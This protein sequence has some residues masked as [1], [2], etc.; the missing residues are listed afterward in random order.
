LSNCD[1]DQKVA[2]A[3]TS[4]VKVNVSVKRS[5]YCWVT[6]QL[7]DCA[8]ISGECR[9]IEKGGE[10]I[11]VCHKYDFFQGSSSVEST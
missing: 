7:S 11:R 8:V 5:G 2:C 6:S 9:N 4:K 1:S 3:L 10:D